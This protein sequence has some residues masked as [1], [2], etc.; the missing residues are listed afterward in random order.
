LDSIQAIHLAYHDLLNGLEWAFTA[1]FALEYGL[2]LYSSPKPPR[3]AF[4]FFGLIDLLAVL[5]AFLALAAPPA[6][7][8][9]G[10]W[11][12]RSR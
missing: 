8:W 6:Q 9:P 5:P 4:S 2:R 1:L 11:G 3:Y 7:H 12:A 10:R